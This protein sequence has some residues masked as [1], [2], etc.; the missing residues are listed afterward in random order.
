MSG[1]FGA[2]CKRECSETLFLGTDYHSHLA[3]GFGGLVTWNKRGMA[4]KIHELGGTQFRAKFAEDHKNMKGNRG[5]GVISGE[6]QPIFLN[7]NLGPFSICVDGRISNHKTL[8]KELHLE[9]ISFSEMGK[10]KGSVNSAEL[11]GRL[12]T[13]GSNFVD[14]IERMFNKIEGSC[15]LLLLSDKGIYAARDK[16]GHTPLV[17]GER[18]GEWAVTSE[19]SAFPNLGF[20][21][22]K[23]LGPGEIVLIDEKGMKEKSEAGSELQICAFLWIYTGFP[24]SDY[25]GINVET[26]R[27]RCGQALARKDNVEVDLVAGVPDSGTTHAIGYAME[28]R[29][30]FRRPLVKYTPS[31]GRSYT[32]P[33]QKIRDRIAQMKLIPIEELTRNKRILLCEDSIVRG[34]QLKNYTLEKLWSSG[35]KEIHVRVACPPLMFP[36]IFNISTRSIKELAARRAIKVLEGKAIE[37][38]SD[39]LDLSTQ[40][41]QK[42]VDQIAKEIKVTSLKYQ[43]LNDMVEAIKLPKEELCLHCWTGS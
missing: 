11:I 10:H 1:M 21:V 28:S 35:A 19:T 14:G 33:S 7:S 18:D 24:A 3:T 4:R 17:I 30:P 42:M 5:I 39:Y 32:P 41:Y 20:K 40:K 34:T 31:Y 9:G 22:R 23:F 2:I 29:I 36:C 26:V 12:I 37:D 38:V 13:R 27:E 16:L 6:E 25:E 8:V 15:S 43:T